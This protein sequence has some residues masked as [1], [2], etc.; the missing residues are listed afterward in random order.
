Q[1]WA[2][3]PPT[4]PHTP[5]TRAIVTKIYCTLKHQ[6]RHATT[7]ASKSRDTIL[8]SHTIDIRTTIESIREQAANIQ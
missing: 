2:L 7:M 4:K 8:T 6:N 3:R 1:L 5:P